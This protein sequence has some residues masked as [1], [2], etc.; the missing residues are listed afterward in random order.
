M[1]T[2]LILPWQQWWGNNLMLLTACSDTKK[3]EQRIK[4][5]AKKLDELAC[6]GLSNSWAIIQILCS[7]FL[8][9]EWAVNNIKSLPHHCCCSKLGWPLSSYSSNKILIYHSFPQ[10]SWAGNFLFIWLVIFAEMWHKKISIVIYHLPPL[11]LVT[12]T[13]CPLW[14]FPP[15]RCLQQ[16]DPA[17]EPAH[18][19]YSQLSHSLHLILEV[20]TQ[21]K[22]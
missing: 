9:S 19:W 14:L 20:T 12:K 11:C 6:I 22:L 2:N 21:T 5:V 17:Y 1:K 15:L 3:Q 10:R 8:M 4:I 13:I 16:L 18:W 7:C